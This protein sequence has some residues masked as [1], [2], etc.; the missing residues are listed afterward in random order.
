MAS[1]CVLSGNPVCQCC[2]RPTP[3]LCLR[4]IAKTAYQK[5]KDP[6]DAA[7]Y[8][9]AMR[10]RTVIAALYKQMRDDR[11]Y[12]FFSKDFSTPEGRTAA[13]KNAYQ[14]LGKQKFESAAAL[15]LL[16]DSLP[17]CVEVIL[18]KLH[19]LQLAMLVCRLYDGELD[20]CPAS[21]RHLLDKVGAGGCRGCLRG[22]GRC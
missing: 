22:T 17:D 11:R 13:K 10:K 7:L 15:F 2:V 1:A 19:D 9:F 5:T 4:Q 16:A 21:L 6:M 20:S 12:R 8:Y 18:T 3:S 14:C